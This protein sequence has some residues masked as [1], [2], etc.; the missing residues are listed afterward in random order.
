MNAGEKV[1]KLHDDTHGEPT[2]NAQETRENPD[3]GNARHMAD[4]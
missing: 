4:W 3:S 2:A 1:L